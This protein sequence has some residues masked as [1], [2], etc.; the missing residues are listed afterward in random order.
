MVR[1]LSVPGGTATAT[2]VVTAN[3]SSPRY[4]L[5]S[6]DPDSGGDEPNSG[7]GVMPANRGGGDDD[8]MA[9]AVGDCPVWIGSGVA[10]S[11]GGDVGRGG[12]G[13]CC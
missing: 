9:V 5:S 7:G 11:G 12:G 13:T 8:V 10:I 6:D 1:D 4:R 3:A 2:A